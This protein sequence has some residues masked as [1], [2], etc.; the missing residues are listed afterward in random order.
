MARI[1]PHPCQGDFT[2][3]LHGIGY[4]ADQSVVDALDRA[5]AWNAIPE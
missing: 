3:P 5:L 2:Q 1:L 4:G